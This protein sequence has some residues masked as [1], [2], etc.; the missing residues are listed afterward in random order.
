MQQLCSNIYQDPAKPET[1][2]DAWSC[3]SEQNNVLVLKSLLL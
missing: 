2:L 3:S 1:I